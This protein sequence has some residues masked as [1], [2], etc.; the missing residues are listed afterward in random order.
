MT[1]KYQCSIWA[2]II[3]GLIVLSNAM[4]LK[5]VWLKCPNPVYEKEAVTVD[6]VKSSLKMVQDFFYTGFSRIINKLSRSA[7]LTMAVQM[8]DL[9][10]QQEF[11]WLIMWNHCTDRDSQTVS[12]QTRQSYCKEVSVNLIIWDILLEE[13][14]WSS[15]HNFTPVLRVDLLYIWKSLSV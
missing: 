11:C 10:A 15:W 14:T 9:K 3:T 13:E 5:Q 7:G 12:E 1:N 4:K 8:A 6:D 2:Q